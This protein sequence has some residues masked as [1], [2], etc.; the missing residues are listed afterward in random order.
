MIRINFGCDGG[1]DDGVHCIRY[2]AAAML[3]MM[4]RMMRLCIMPMTVIDE[5][6]RMSF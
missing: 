6:I 2:Y 4:V 5:M 1:I 3:L